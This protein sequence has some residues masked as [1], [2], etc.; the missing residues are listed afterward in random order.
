[1]EERLLLMLYKN[2]TFIK[3]IDLTAAH[4]SS[5]DSASPQLSIGQRTKVFP[6]NSGLV[7]RKDGDTA[8]VA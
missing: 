1:M 5:L 4:Q 7:A 6:V 3:V 2:G 8:A